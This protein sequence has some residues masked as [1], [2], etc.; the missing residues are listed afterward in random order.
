MF[1]SERVAPWDGLGMEP[2]KSDNVANILDSMGMNWDVKSM[3]VYFNA[4]GDCGLTP[5][6]NVKANVRSDNN[7]VLGVVS[8]KY[9]IVQ[10]RN[11]F[12]FI[13]Y[14]KPM[15]LEIIKGGYFNDRKLWLAGEFKDMMVNLDGDMVKMYEVFTTTHDGKGSVRACITPIRP[16][17]WNILNLAFAKSIRSWSITHIGDVQEKLRTAEEAIELTTIYTQVFQK[18]AEQLMDIKVNKDT[19]EELTSQLFPIPTGASEQKEQVMLDRRAIVTDIFRHAPDLGR[20]TGWDFVNA[21]SDYA[22]HYL[23]EYDIPMYRNST[24]HKAIDGHPLID[25]AY[26]LIRRVA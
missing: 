11:A 8:D 13:D 22:M 12:G 18:Q 1:T 9:E 3:D 23:P 5:I 6:P 15:G 24:F 14:M 2:T 17:C 21:V 19:M 16:A 7:H 26:Q 20:G 10:N 4:Y 25:Q